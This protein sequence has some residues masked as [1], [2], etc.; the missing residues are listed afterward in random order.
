[1]IRMTKSRGSLR[2][3][4]TVVVVAL[5]LGAC[6]NPPSPSPSAA[7]SATPS[8]AASSAAPTATA[9]A[10]AACASGDL[11]VTGGPWGGAAGSRGS[12]IV[13]ENVGTAACLLPAAATVALVDEAGTVLLTNAPPEA[14]SGPELAPGATT[15]FSVVFGNWCDQGVALP[16]HLEL[17]LSGDTA[18]IDGLTVATSDDLPPCN[19]PG[20]PATLSTTDWQAG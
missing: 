16:L 7:A 14:G 17:A 4:L 9:T 10:V 3:A 13:V 6:G 12:D 1:M 2:L 15:G 8:A 20:D 5:F 18:D 11:Q 19:G